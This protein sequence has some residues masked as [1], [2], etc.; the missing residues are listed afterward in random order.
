PN[1][2]TPTQRDL[3][4]VSSLV[5]IKQRID[6]TYVR[7]IDDKT[8]RE[9][10]IAGMLQVLD[11]HSFYVPPAQRQAFDEQ[12]EGTYRGVGILVERDSSG[13]GLVVT[14][15]LPESPAQEAGILA[16]DRIIEVE[17][18]DITELE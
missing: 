12:I 2:V 10:A 3:E 8:L 4:F 14:R 18:E 1:R 11:R 17:G 7:P 9:G 15:P 5:E 13:E 6:Q 16:G